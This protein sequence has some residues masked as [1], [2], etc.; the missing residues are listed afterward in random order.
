MEPEDGRKRNQLQAILGQSIEDGL[1]E[2]L[3]QSGLQ[4]VLSHAPIDRLAADPAVLHDV[5]KSIFGEGGSA[6]IERE[7]SRKLLDK[8]GIEW[9]GLGRLHRWWFS[10]TALG[11]NRPGRASAREKEVLRHFVALSAFPK[12]H[13]N[14]GLA[15]GTTLR[16]RGPSLELTSLRFADAFKRET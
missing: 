15:D 12:D 6:I 7:I 8:V 10:A 14:G 16:S 4:M 5:L 2:V 1:R 9:A 3:G 13:S 11:A